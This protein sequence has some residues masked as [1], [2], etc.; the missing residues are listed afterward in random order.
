MVHEL[1][2]EVVKV[3][4]SSGTT[5]LFLCDGCIPVVYLLASVPLL[6]IIVATILVTMVLQRYIYIYTYI[7]IYS[8]YIYSFMQSMY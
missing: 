4:V 7:Y 5:Q 8:M 3:I 1:S 2:L 6:T